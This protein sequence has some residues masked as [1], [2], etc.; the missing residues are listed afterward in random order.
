[1]TPETKSIQELTGKYSQA[2]LDAHVVF[3][4]NGFNTA[5][6]TMPCSTHWRRKTAATAA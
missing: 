4:A 5:A 2:H 6:S 3:A 1:M